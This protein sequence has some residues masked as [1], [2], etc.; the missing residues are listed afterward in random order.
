M[1]GGDVVDRQTVPAPRET[2]AIPS[3][4]RGHVTIAGDL[5]KGCALCVLYC[6]PAVLAIAGGLNRH[7]YHAA[8]YAGSGCTGCAICFYVCP[9]PGAVTVY[10]R[11]GRHSLPATV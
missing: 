4:E 1:S 7:G 3:D 9:E 10:R 2:V 11:E 6:P 8:T 5:C